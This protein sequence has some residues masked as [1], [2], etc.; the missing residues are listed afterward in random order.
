MK[1]FGK[2]LNARVVWLKIHLYLA[3]A[4]GFVIALLGLT[5]SLSVYRTEI[6]EWLNPELVIDDPRGAR[7]SPDRLMAAVR[8][9]HPDRTGIWTLE[10]PASP[11]GM[12]TAWYEKPRET[13][14]EWYAPLMVSVNPYTAE[15]V[16]SR[17]WGHT[18]TTWLLDVH[19]H[20]R[21]GAAGRHWV[22]L[23]GA[24]LMLSAVSGLY[25]WRPDVR[26]LPG[27]FKIA[28][29]GGVI[30][31]LF[32]LHRTLGWLNA[33]ALLI[34]AATG[35]FLSL[36]GLTEKLAGAEG[37]HHGLDARQVAST[38][39][40]NANPPR[41]A[42]ALAVAQGAFGKAEPRYITTPVGDSGTF[43]ISLR[44]PFEVNRRHPRT[45][46]WVD[47]WNGQIKDIKDPA[48]FS[49]AGKLA[50]R[51]WPLHTG[52]AI[53]GIGRFLWF[54]AGL[55]LCFLYVSGVLRWLVRIGLVKDRPMSRAAL[56]LWVS[57]RRLEMT[58]AARYAGGPGEGRA[59]RLFALRAGALRIAAALLDRLRRHGGGLLDRLNR[60]CGKL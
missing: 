24:A 29:Q 17:F 19:V 32:D 36:P 54:L 3:L 56:R 31:F 51:L 60:A 46:V 52:E 12:A 38:G 7:Q 48:G 13:F 40:R 53:G 18:L 59:R 58:G 9:A 1:F 14:F 27:A 15:V 10:F 22:G 42:A 35:L 11:R 55:S 25:L 8:R 39:V 28:R 6:D 16:A 21:S 20:L 49:A 5:G 45:V 33:A 47:R 30:R 41:L 4:V 34:L 37:A 2:P 43:R 44:Q 23:L 26:S 57:R 50:A